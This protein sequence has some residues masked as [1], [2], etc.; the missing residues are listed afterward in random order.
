MTTV[1][2]ILLSVLCF[3]LSQNQLSLS[4][5][6]QDQQLLACMK[7]FAH[8]RILR[9]QRVLRKKEAL[10]HGEEAVALIRKEDQKPLAALGALRLGQLSNVA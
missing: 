2:T 4:A 7:G 1:P 8:R 9:P 5:A 6:R 3:F 10:P